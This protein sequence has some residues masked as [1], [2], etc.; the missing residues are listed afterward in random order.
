MTTVKTHELKIWPEYFKKV[1]SRAKTAELRF[2]DRDFLIGDWLVLREWMP[3]KK[4]YTGR[5]VRRVISDIT[6]LS[7][8]IPLSP[9]AQE[10]CFGWCVLHMGEY[11]EEESKP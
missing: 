1:K 8:V 11:D 3:Q 6:W 10:E 5:Q 7:S 9:A 2:D 4:E